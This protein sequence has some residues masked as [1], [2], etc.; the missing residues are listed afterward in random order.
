MF[1]ALIFCF[2]NG[3]VIAVIKRKWRQH[4]L[5][6]NGGGKRPLCSQTSGTV[7]K[8]EPRQS[9]KPGAACQDLVEDQPPP[10]DSLLPGRQAGRAGE[11]QEEEGEEDQIVLA[12]VRTDSAGPYRM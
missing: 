11:D 7:V 5:M 10:Y 8:Q 12:V 2:F 3:E 4:R 6:K 9:L 1:V